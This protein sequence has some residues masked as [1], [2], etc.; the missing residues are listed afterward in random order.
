MKT[1][2]FRY[3]FA[4]IFLN[5]YMSRTYSQTYGDADQLF[6]DALNGYNKHVRP[7]LNQTDVL[8]VNVSYDIVGIQDINEVEGTLTVYFQFQYK[9]FDE[10]I[11]WNPNV[12][13][14]TGTIALPVDAVWKPELVLTNPAGPVTT[15]DSSMTTVRY[16]SNGQALWF[17]TGIIS[18][19][20]FID[21]K[22]YPFDTQSC[23][24]YFSVSNYLSSEMS[25]YLVNKVAPLAHYTR[26]G[27][28][29]LSKT[30]ATVTDRGVQAFKVTLSMVR[31]PTFVALIIL[32][33]IMILSFLNMLVFFIPADSGERISFTITLLLSQTVFLT[34]VS[35]SIPH[36]SNPLAIL[37]YFIGLQVLLSAIIC[38][39][40]ILNLNLYH[41]DPEDPVPL[42][43]CRLF[44]KGEVKSGT[45]ENKHE[46]LDLHK[47][48][49]DD[50]NAKEKSS[51]DETDKHDLKLDNTPTCRNP[52]TYID[53]ATKD[54]FG[55]TWKDISKS[56]DTLLFVGSVLYFVI[57]CIIFLFV[58]LF[59]ESV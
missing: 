47:I 3:E 10:K 37:C 22:Y 20:C 35:D 11:S 9:W 27:V 28:W 59:R 40:T 8:Q 38:V 49:S 2:I 29:D 58:I 57:V 53:I 51:S 19:A 26:S 15:V 55:F 13:N 14:N 5:I 39:V 25:L 30:E 46:K 48:K 21:I 44:R 12:Y 52:Q 4:L 24:L 6:M 56:F 41:K 16:Y 23:P 50:T 17:P 32:A 45:S 43:I 34:I 1:D 18:I 31:R 54:S 33:P 42:W 36:T 7:V